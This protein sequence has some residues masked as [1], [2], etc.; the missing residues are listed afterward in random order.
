MNWI[1]GVFLYIEKF[2]YWVYCF[3][4]QLECRLLDILTVIKKEFL[5]ILISIMSMIPVPAAVENFQLPQIPSGIGWAV[6][7]LAL[8][9]A[10]ALIVA[11]ATIRITMKF[12]ASV[13]K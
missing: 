9:E 8:P 12:L 5:T 7:S 4:G 2:W 6:D 10:M 3:F 13:S 1:A 11:A